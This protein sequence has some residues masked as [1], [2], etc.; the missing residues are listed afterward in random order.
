MGDFN[1]FSGVE[2]SRIWQNKGA[3]GYFEGGCNSPKTWTDR[4]G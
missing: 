3:K 1:W 4:P 2:K